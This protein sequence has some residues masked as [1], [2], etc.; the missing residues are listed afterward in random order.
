MP[1]P[2]PVPTKPVP[3]WM[4]GLARLDSLPIGSEFVLPGGRIG[5][6]TIADEWQVG[7]VYVHIPSLPFSGPARGSLLVRPVPRPL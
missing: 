7:E 3:R 5:H 6:V 4:I 2:Y 1:W